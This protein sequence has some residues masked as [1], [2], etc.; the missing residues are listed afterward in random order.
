MRMGQWEWLGIAHLLRPGRSALSCLVACAYEFCL[1]TSEIEYENIEVLYASDTL[2]ASNASIISSEDVFINS[3]VRAICETENKD[4]LK[5]SP[6]S[7]NGSFEAGLNANSSSSSLSLKLK[8]ETTKR[9]VA[10]V[11]VMPPVPSTTTVDSRL[12]LKGTEKNGKSKEDPFFNLLTGGNKK[13]S[14]F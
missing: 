13:S 9:K 8:N 11:S 7:N 5:K 4:G 2:G 3:S 1:K 6:D 12:H 14:L 10:F